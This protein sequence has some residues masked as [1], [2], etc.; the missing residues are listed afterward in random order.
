[1]SLPIKTMWTFLGQSSWDT[2]TQC[3]TLQLIFD[4]R[5]DFLRTEFMD[6]LSLSLSLSF[7]LRQ[8]NTVL[9]TRHIVT[10][11]HTH[12]HTHTTHTHTHTLNTHFY[13]DF[14]DKSEVEFDG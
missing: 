1:M 9:Y 6:V 2:A 3:N 14:A 8:Y 5:A 11:T 12:T 13:H 4:C 7:S 10:Y